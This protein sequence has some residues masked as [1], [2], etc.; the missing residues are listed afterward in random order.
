MKSAVFA[1]FT[2]L[3]LSSLQANVEKVPFVDLVQ[4]ADL[5]FIG[6]AGNQECRLAPNGRTIVTSFEFT[7]VQTV[8]SKHHARQSGLNT[9]TLQQPG[10]ELNGE[11]QSICCASS[12][13]TGKR[14]L[15]FVKDDGQLYSNALV[16]AHQGKFTL[17]EDTSTKDLY[18]VSWGG[19]AIIDFNGLDIIK[20][21][22]PILD[23]QNA[24]V[25]YRST[26][27]GNFPFAPFSDD[28]SACSSNF[29]KRN[30]QDIF[31]LDDF[32]ELIKAI[33]V[34]K[35]E[36]PETAKMGRF[37]SQDEN[38]A[39]YSEPLKMYKAGSANFINKK[40]NPTG[41]YKIVDEL[42]AC[43]A[44]DLP[45]VMEQ[46]SSSHWSHDVHDAC[47]Y[48]Y[49]RHMNVFS[50]TSQD[51]NYGH[52]NDESEFGGWIGSTALNSEYGFQWG[53]WSIALCYNWGYGDCGQI[54]ESDIFYNPY[55][56]WTDNF[57]NAFANGELLL[58]DRVCLHELGHS[59]GY[60]MGIY[61]EVNYDYDYPTV[62]FSYNGYVVEDGKGIHFKD[63]ENL[64]DNYDNQIS[65][66]TILDMGVESY[67]ASDGWQ[68]TTA[69]Q[70]S[71][72]PGEFI[73]VSGLTVENIGNTDA[74]NVS[75]QFYLS[76]NRNITDSD[77]P[78]GNSYS[79][80]NFPAENYHVG[81]YTL[82]IPFGLNE[83]EYYLGVIMTVDGGGDDYSSNNAT[84]LYFDLT[85]SESDFS[86]ANAEQLN[87]NELE[88]ANNGSG[89]N[90][91]SSYPCLSENES[92]PELL[93]SFELEAATEV[94]I[95]LSNLSADLDL[96]LFG[97]CNPNNCMEESSGSGSENITVDLEAGEYYVMVDGDQGAESD[98][99]LKIRKESEVEIRVFL[100]GALR[101]S[102]SYMI[103]ELASQGVLNTEHPYDLPAIPNASLPS[104]A[105]DWVVVEARSASDYQQV[106]ERRVGILGS[107]GYIV[108]PISGG[109]LLFYELYDSRDYYF[110]V[111]HRNHLAVVSSSAVSE[112]GGVYEWNF[113]NGA[114]KAMGEEQ[115]VPVEVDGST[116]YSLYAGDFNQ[117]NAIQ[118]TDFDE[119]IVES[120][121]IQT[122]S[123][124]DANLDGSIQVTDY[125]LW[126]LNKAKIGIL[127]D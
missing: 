40:Q 41:D 81:D 57:E 75:I 39:T 109:N 59:W 124:A 60:V 23:I 28:A 78:I 105:V 97:S 64:R 31:S 32:V 126:F 93:Y 68:R 37:Y 69:D 26:S 76:T 89:S 48:H 123:K 111:H 17:I 85:L 43:G 51:G 54:L 108:D 5:V 107:N 100:Q 113:S 3:L 4:E 96:L 56:D 70:S 122:Y 116:R 110:S 20:T 15:L 73:E 25:N 86:C 72:D 98:F 21:L 24:M 50:S 61:D 74:E 33:P 67:F 2:F 8:R 27:A 16:A 103:T 18:P 118:A 83:G 34:G 90:I 62:M 9:I 79:W 106:L 30:S 13:S 84:S 47:M 115:V 49:D 38:G 112:S 36:K 6:T 117:D 71:Y 92:G 44:H 87:V 101:P 58:L 80:T 77:Y 119:W 88:T 7:D 10:G 104:N 19:K 121:A 11:K 99:H 91:L 55:R 63:A 14:Y 82:E 114:N 95:E 53:T 65:E 52:D 42:G 46:T 12:F 35:A 125:D 94:E 45:I 22:E 66:E 127:Q 102:D 1:L 29:S 120:A